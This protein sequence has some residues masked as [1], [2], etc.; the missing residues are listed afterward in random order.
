ME[1]NRYIAFIDIL[2]TKDYATYQPIRYIQSIINF[3]NA[4]ISNIEGN[5]NEDDRVYFF[6]DGAFIETKDLLSLIKYL[7][8]IRSELSPS[9][10]Y[11]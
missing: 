7:Q 10:L 2:G 6:S 5:L 4:L 1:A 3:Q 8:S 9:R 11:F